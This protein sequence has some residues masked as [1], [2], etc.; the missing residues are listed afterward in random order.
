MAELRSPFRHQCKHFSLSAAQPGQGVGAAGCP[1]KL[2]HHLRV[3]GGASRRHPHQR[4]YEVGD[5][6]D[7]VFEQVAD[8]ARTASEQF[9]GVAR[10]DVLGEHQDPYTGDDFGAGRWRLAAPHR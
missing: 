4:F 8:P 1:H 2:G 6:G 3:E 9:G 10:L 7:P 5:V